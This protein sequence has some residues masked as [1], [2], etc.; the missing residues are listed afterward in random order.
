MR[1]TPEQQ[2]IG[3]MGVEHLSDSEG[4]LFTFPSSEMRR[5]WSFGC[6]ISLDVGFL[7]DDLVLR[8]IVPLPAHPFWKKQRPIHTQA[9]LRKA[10]METTHSY[11]FAS[12]KAAYRYVIELPSGWFERH[13][14]DVGAKL[15]KTDTFSYFSP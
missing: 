11:F 1:K 14:V 13:K 2:T 7:D 9:D 3:L 6:L 12:S 4:M 8:E 10:L 5:F 15:H